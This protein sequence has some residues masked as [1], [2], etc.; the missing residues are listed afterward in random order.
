[1]V[2][3]GDK[4]LPACCL[5]RVQGHGKMTQLM[6]VAF[7][8]LCFP[9]RVQIICV[10]WKAMALLLQTKH[11]PALLSLQPNCIHPGSQAQLWGQ[12]SWLWS[13]C[14]KC[15]QQDWLGGSCAPQL[16]VPS[17]LCR[18]KPRHVLTRVRAKS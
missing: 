1:M 16:P 7:F 4:N 9:Y 13:E 3:H 11:S 18:S 17:P 10:V 2:E 5:L 6:K 15:C 14:Q 8:L 12:E